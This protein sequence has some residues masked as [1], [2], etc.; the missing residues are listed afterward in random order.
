MKCKLPLIRASI[1]LLFF[2]SHLLLP[3]TSKAQESLCVVNGIL[4]GENGQPLSGASVIIRNAKTNFISGTKSDSSGVFTIHVPAGG[5][6]GF[7]FS[8]VGYEPQS[9]SGYNFKGGATVTLNIAMKATAGS[10][11]QVV[12]IGYGS[13]RK[14][15]VT[16]AITSITSKA[17]TDVPSSNLNQAL[18]GQGA[19]IDIQK[20]NGNS[21][22]GQVPSILIRGARSVKADNGPLFVI[23]GI[24][25][26]GNINDLNVDDIASVEVLKDASSTAIYGSRGANGVILVS[27]KRGNAGSP[28]ITYSGYVGI[29]NSLGELPMMTG[30]QFETFKKW[31]NFLGKPAVYTSIDDPKILTDNFTAEELQGVANNRS[32]D[33][34]KLAIKQGIS[35]NHHLGFSGGTDM[36]KY[37]VSTGYHKETGVYP[38]QSFERFS[39]KLTLDQQLSKIFK[40]GISSMNTYTSIQGENKNILVDKQNPMDQ[41]LKSNPLV[42]PYDSSGNIVNAFVPGNS[43]QV[44]NILANFVDGAVVEKRKRLGTFT[45]FYTEANIAKGLRYRFNAGAQLYSEDYGNFYAGKTT[46]NQGGLS[47]ASNFSAKARNYTLENILT[48]DKTIASIHR[49]GFTGLFSYQSNVLDSTAFGY[50]GLLSD[51]AQFYNPSLA[52][53]LSGTGGMSEFSLISYMARVNYSLNNKY[54]LTLTTRIDASSRLASGNQYH[55]F[56]SAA[57]GWNISREAFMLNSKTVSN[58]K[59][60][61]SYGSVGNTSISPYQTLGSLAPL[62]YNYGTINTTGLYPNSVPNPSLGWEYTSTANLG[63]DF[64]FFR[65]RISGSLEL[66][67]SYTRDMILPQTL[68]ATSGIPST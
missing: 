28:I 42:S 45:T 56:P 7:T 49:I 30:S 68:P 25:F 22:P 60:R 48:Y 34:Q 55:S 66:Y 65:N 67:H 11:D 18:Q 61:L 27:T 33:W 51:N 62:V 58:L 13:Q 36:T 29:T 38:G 9:L 43:N 6:Y 31:A 23:D 4:H 3:I 19:G 26:D 64:G 2:L 12:V 24:P 37:S 47:K 8:N 41:V 32:T 53:N 46:F 21:H 63:V 54:L 16:G 35:T 17:L 20:N 14:V 5:P 15:D 52:S 44:W 40:V 10:M 50:S 39:V 59:L 57:L 1:I